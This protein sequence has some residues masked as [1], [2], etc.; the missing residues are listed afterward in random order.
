MGK[1]RRKEFIEPTL[2][3][4]NEINKTRFSFQCA[5][6]PDFFLLI[7]K[8]ISMMISIAKVMY[9]PKEEREKTGTIRLNLIGFSSE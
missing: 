6:L 9:K 3:F 7:N 1:H 4:E 8:V 2:S 5:A